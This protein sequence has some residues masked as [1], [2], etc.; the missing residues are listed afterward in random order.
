MR[1]IFKD[2]QDEAAE[3]NGR[4]LDSE[5]GLMQVLQNARLLPPFIA[6]LSGE[7]GYTLTVGLGGEH[8]CIQYAASDGSPPYRV[9]LSPDL[10]TDEIEFMCGG[11][12]T[13]I[14]PRHLL[15]F[16]VLSRAV[17]YFL[18]TGQRFPDLLWEEI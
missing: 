3:W 12:P 6:E 9:A 4:A 17:R 18:L 14:A 13:P 8:G 5:A 10:K 15:E 11:T 7:H 16:D 2:L 1:V